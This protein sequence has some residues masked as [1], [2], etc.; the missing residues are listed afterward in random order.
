MEVGYDRA[1]RTVRD[2]W[3]PLLDERVD[4]AAANPKSALQE[5]AVSG[6]RA[7]PAYRVVT[8]TGPDHNPQFVVEVSVEGE[9]PARGE[10]G[11]LQAAQKAAA[12]ALLETRRAAP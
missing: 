3:A 12:L 1:A 11:S 5:W 10:G 9:A 6:G 4:P 2:L 8:R 7:P